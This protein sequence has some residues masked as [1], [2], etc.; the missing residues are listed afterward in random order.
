MGSTVPLWMQA[1]LWGLLSGGALVVG[2]AVGY[3]VR[4][5]AGTVAAVMAF[6]AGVL[7]SALSFELVLEAY[8]QSGLKA[9]AIGFTAGAVVYSIA[10]WL[11]AKQ[12]ARHR[13]R[14]GDQQPSED[15]QAGS[16]TAIAVGALLDGIPE[17]IAIG[18]TMLAGGAVSIATVVAI[19]VSNV[20][21]GLSSSAGMKKAGRTPGFIFGLWSAIAVVSGLASLAGYTAFGNVSPELQAA[22]TGSAAGAILAML[23]DTMIPEAFEGTHDYSG[24]IA[25]VGF[26]CSFALSV[27]GG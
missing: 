3:T 24:L 11:V 26:L 13:K 23:M 17:S 6:G 10:N 16:G 20:P 2:A 25:A 19:F 12:G 22:T 14:S 15:E 9:T 5:S 27:I 1:G 8:K 18:L 21:E 7:V 4:L